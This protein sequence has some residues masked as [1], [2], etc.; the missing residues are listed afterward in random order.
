VLALLA[1][2]VLPAGSP[3]GSPIGLAVI[4]AGAGTVAI[5]AVMPLR[6]F[7]LLT[8]LWGIAPLLAYAGAAVVC[9]ARVTD[10]PRLAR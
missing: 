7:P 1:L 8:G 3:A 4:A 9:M 2:A 6:V 5:A 10:N